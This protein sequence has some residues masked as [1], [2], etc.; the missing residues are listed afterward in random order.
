MEESNLELYLVAINEKRL[1]N[2]ISSVL[3]YVAVLSHLSLSL[4]SLSL[5][6]L[7]L[8]SLSLSLQSFT[9]LCALFRN[10]PTV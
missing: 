5:S 2:S 3:S 4:L 8:L 9:V 6:P 1:M 10:L 7:S